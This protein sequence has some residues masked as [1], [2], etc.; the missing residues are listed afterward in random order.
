MKLSELHNIIFESISSV[1]NKSYEDRSWR[2]INYIKGFGSKGKLPSFSG[3]IKELYR[4]KFNEAYEWASESSEEVRRYGR[5]W[6]ERDIYVETIGRWKFNKRNL[7]YVERSIDLDMDEDL[8]ELKYKSIG[9]CWSWKKSNSESY[10]SNISL[11]KNNVARVV[12][13]GYV[14]PLSIDWLETIYINLYNMKNET[15]IRMNDDAYV[16]VS[17]ILINGVKYSMGGSYIINA[18]SDKYNKN[19]ENW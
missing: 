11:L 7:V 6:A 13:C 2:I 12:I 15:E 16:E 3:S 5:V 8:G 19:R 4:E 9:E 18:S 10:C 17:H 1:I 14:N